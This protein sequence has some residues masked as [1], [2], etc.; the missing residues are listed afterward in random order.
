MLRSN[1]PK[2]PRHP[3]LIQGLPSPRPSWDLPVPEG[4]PRLQA[5][6]VPRAPCYIQPPPFVLQAMCVNLS[7]Q[8][9]DNGS[10][11]GVPT[12]TYAPVAP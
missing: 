11:R 5:S 10:S 2:D 4:V 1:T 7:L 9:W 12:Y 3:T 6:A 8:H